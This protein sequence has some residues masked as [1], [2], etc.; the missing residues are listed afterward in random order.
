MNLKSI[1]ITRIGG[2]FFGTME[3]GGADGMFKLNL[4]DKEVDRILRV[5][6]KAAKDMAIDLNVARPKLKKADGG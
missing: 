3:V 1:R 5:A 2:L 6:K 4:D